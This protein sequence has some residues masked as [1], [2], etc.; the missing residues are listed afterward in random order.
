MKILENI[1]PVARARAIIEN[2]SRPVVT[3]EIFTWADTVVSSSVLFFQWLL[4]E[5]REKPKDSGVIIEKIVLAWLE[6]N[7]DRVL[8]NKVTRRDIIRSSGIGKYGAATY[9]KVLDS[10]EAMELYVIKEVSGTGG[11][12]K[13][14]I[15][16][17]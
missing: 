7:R 8:A 9:S 3:V 5:F 6:K 10:M 2:P 16:T 4:G 11:G 14:K 17:F 15:V 12:R 1:L 13:K